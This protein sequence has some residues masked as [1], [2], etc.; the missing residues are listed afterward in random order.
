MPVWP[1]AYR[2][3]HGVSA[4]KHCVATPNWGTFTD[5]RGAARTV[6]FAG[7]GMSVLYKALQKAAKENE[8]RQ[9]AS[10]A[11]FDP[12]RLAG[13][14]V[15]RVGSGPNKWRLAS[16]A[17]LAVALIAMGAAYY[18]TS[19]APGTQVAAV[20]HPQPAVTPT[21]PPAGSV[22][23]PA[24]AAGV[25]VPA[26]QAPGAPT[27]APIQGDQQIAVAQAPPPRP[28]A[29]PAAQAPV[30]KAEALAPVQPAAPPAPPAT[31]AAAKQPAAV[32]TQ[33]KV[34]SDAPLPSKVPPPPMTSLRDPMPQIAADSPARMLDPPISVR[35]SQMDLE[36][37]GSAVQVRTVSQDAQDLVGTAYNALI[38]GEYDMAL[39]YYDKAL[40]QEPHSLLALLGRGTALQ[41][42]GRKDEARGAYE[43][44]LKYD[45]QNREALSDITA[46]EAERTPGEALQ[47]LM[48]LEREYPNFSPIKAQIGMVCARMEDYEGALDWLRR[49]L[50]ITPDAT[51]YQYNLA[52]VLDRLGRHEEAVAAYQQVLS[53][54]TSGR[55]LPE[56]SSADIQRRVA[57]LTAR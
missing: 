39:G 29:A 25:P 2:F 50:A 44:V 47:R 8:Q 53:S 11:N 48:D 37:V 18:F 26:V 7:S 12:D 36:G 52:L 1:F 23:P 4:A 43:Q 3:A 15:I 10:P 40:K 17:F 54:M 24:P 22:T 27:A 32:E 38:R 51:M 19:I 5:C 13:S 31:S 46:L 34:A 42:L 9:A 49:A 28:A 14:G 45:P 30:E 20:S 16:L 55:S 21:P 56:L 41:K 57:Y 33:K 6:K 35:R